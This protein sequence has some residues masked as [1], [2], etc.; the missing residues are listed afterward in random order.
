MPIG[1]KLN[2]L[3]RKREKVHLQTERGID[4]DKENNGIIFV[5]RYDN[6]NLYFPGCGRGI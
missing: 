2:I 4:H 3:K 1:K 5:H 6:I